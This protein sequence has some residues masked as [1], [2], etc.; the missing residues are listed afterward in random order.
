MLS[1]N[2]LDEYREILHTSALKIPERVKE[3]DKGYFVVYNHKEGY[4]E[5]HHEYGLTTRDSLQL[6]IPFKELDQRTIDRILETKVENAKALFAKMER[7][8]AKIEEEMQRKSDEV[9]EEIS[10]DIFRYCNNNHPS[11][12]TIDDEAYTTKFI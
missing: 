12:D 6:W 1:Q 11:K 2:W 5:I 8:N 7:E 10:R 9:S 3:I 4:F